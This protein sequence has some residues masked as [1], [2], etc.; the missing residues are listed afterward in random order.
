MVNI[1]VK[2]AGIEFRN[3]VMNAAGPP[4]RNGEALQEVAKG[5]AGGLVAK[6]ISVNPAEVP[7]PCMIVVDRGELHFSGLFALQERLV[8]VTRSTLKVPRGLMNVE[9]WSDLPY[10]QWLEKEYGVAKMT[11]LPLIASIGYTADEV[12]KLG[13][14][15]QRAGVDAIEFSTHYLGADPKP[16]IEVTKTL[17][18]VVEI[19]IFAKLSPHAVDIAMFAKAVEAAGADGIVA[20]NSLGPCLHIDIETGKPLLGGK[21]GFGWLSGPAI[22]PLAIRCV[23]DIARTV[24]ISVVGVGGIMNGADAIEHIMAGASA[25][26]VCSGAILEGPTIYRRIADEIRGFL[27]DHGFDSIE[28]IRGMAL[29]YLPE[30]PLRTEAIPPFVDEN[31]CKGCKICEQV[32]SYHAIKL[33]GEGKTL[34]VVIDEDKCYGCGLCVS[35]CPTRA[36]VLKEDA[37]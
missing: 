33:I 29:P 36:L 24:K 5:G 4:G 15:V 35:I 17:R 13:P 31:L 23:A 32:C 14:L 27:K 18:E 37:R 25:I 11:E 28:D 1:S 20:I 6:T 3:P 26:Q 19:P 10:K 8:R 16:V 30:K 22:K 21:D 12:M 7:R 34:K 9:L 2:I